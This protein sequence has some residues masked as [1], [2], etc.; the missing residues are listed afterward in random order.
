MKLQRL[1]KRKYVCHYQ[2]HKINYFT[3][4]S[5]FNLLPKPIMSNGCGGELHF[6]WT[7]LMKELHEIRKYLVP[8]IKN[9]LYTSDGAA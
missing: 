9:K 1:L 3:K 7:R 6:S 5:N 4:I 2:I 8:S